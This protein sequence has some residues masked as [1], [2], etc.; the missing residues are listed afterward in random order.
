MFKNMLHLK[1]ISLLFFAIG[2]AGIGVLQFIYNAPR[3]VI[4]PV[5]PAWLGPAGIWGWVTGIGFIA[6]AVAVVVNRWAKQAA[7]LCAWFLLLCCLLIGVPNQLHFYPAHL[8][9]WTNVLKEL[10][11]SGCALVAAANLQYNSAPTSF[12][13]VLEKL[14]PAGL[15][16]F[17]IMHLL[18]GV[19]HF[20]YPDFVSSLIAAWIPGHLFFTYLSGVALIAAGAGILLNIQRR[21]AAYLLAA[22]LFIWVLVLHLPRAV[23]NPGGDES[24]EWTSVFEALAFSGVAFLIGTGA[25]RKASQPRQEIAIAHS[26]GRAAG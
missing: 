12:F 3:P 22:I 9:V 14:I 21:L 20:F 7:L 15:Y 1:K 19:D 24:N 6:M 18:F 26:Q 5:V 16:F 10:C 17:G 4:M 13:R 11:L 23:A 25:R 8:G 2:M